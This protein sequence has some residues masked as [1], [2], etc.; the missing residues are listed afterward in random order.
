MKLLAFVVTAGRP[1]LLARTVE[2]VLAALPLQAK[3]FVLVNGSHAATEEWLGRQTDSRLGWR[4]VA[5]EARTRA[6]NRAFSQECD[7]VQFFDDDVIVPLNFFLE[8]ATLMVR[9]PHV[10]IWGGPN[11]TPLSSGFFENISGICLSSR[12]AV[13][14]A[15]IRYRAKQSQL[16]ASPDDFCLCNLAVRC[17]DVP[18]SLRFRHLASN[19]ENVFLRQASQAG[20][21]LG[22]S[23]NLLVYHHRRS[24][25]GS[26]AKQIFS[27]GVGRGQQF[28]L[29]P[30]ASLLFLAL[31]ALFLSFL[32][33]CVAKGFSPA[34]VIAGGYFW[35]AIS[36][37][38]EK[39]GSLWQRAGALLPVFGLI[40]VIH[41]A[42]AMGE[43]G[44]DLSGSLL[45][46]RLRFGCE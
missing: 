2:S 36:T 22:F 44:V 3:L 18:A 8:L 15:A 46:G 31:P 10:D 38:T 34:M 39:Q 12:W 24:G 35:L 17:A 29:Q 25:L 43:M 30:L 6:R 11:L 13:F 9:N 20:L 5:K 28:R 27:Y 23:E 21:H 19:E 16:P 42:Y 45:D 4:V 37:A 26:F 7:L 32:G 1:A 41:V 40:P 14:G 33:L